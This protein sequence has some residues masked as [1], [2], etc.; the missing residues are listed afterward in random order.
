[1]TL[2]VLVAILLLVGTPHAGR[3]SGWW[4]FPALELA[5]LVVIA[6]RDPGR[7]DDRSRTVRRLTIGLIA[8]MTVGTLAAVVVLVHDILVTVPGV[9]GV[10]LLA[11]G[12]AV[13]FTNVIVFSLWYW[14][15]DRGGPAERAAGSGVPLSFAFPENAMPAFV[16]SDWQPRYPDYLYLAFTNATAF[17]PTDTMPVRTWAKMTMLLQAAISLVTGIL[18]IARAINDLPG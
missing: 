15:L 9:S 5:L 1:M 10:T 8:V 16:A 17:S 4:I 12:G 3:L 7:I 2:A 18:V 11:R 14:E 6:I 13:W